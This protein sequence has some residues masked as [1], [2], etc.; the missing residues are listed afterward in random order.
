MFRFF[1]NNNYKGLSE[2]V[3]FGR[4]LMGGT[5]P[6]RRDSTLSGGARDGERGH[7]CRGRTQLLDM[8]ES[9]VI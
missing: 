3:T 4:H 5:K 9:H 1:K 8:R 6:H 2:E 7:G